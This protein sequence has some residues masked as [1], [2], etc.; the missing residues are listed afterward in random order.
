MSQGPG[1]PLNPAARTIPVLCQVHSSWFCN[2]T[3]HRAVLTFLCAPSMSLLSE[4]LRIWSSWPATP[5]HLGAEQG[6]L[7]TSPQAQGKLWSGPS[8]GRAAVCLFFISEQPSTPES[9]TAAPPS[10]VAGG[11][12]GP[13]PPGTAVSGWLF[14]QMSGLPKGGT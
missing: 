5:C 6:P 14:S 7:P 2:L 9:A 11:H 13:G 4:L 8:I 12:L 1:V 10:Q 3:D